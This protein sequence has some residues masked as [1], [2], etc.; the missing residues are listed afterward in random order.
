MLPFSIWMKLEGNTLSE[1]SQ[2]KTNTN[3]I[4]CMWT[5][6]SKTEKTCPMFVVS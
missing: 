2:R 1:M 5:L 6:K 3:T 4:I